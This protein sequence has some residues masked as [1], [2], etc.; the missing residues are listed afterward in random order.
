M[1][2][3]GLTVELL[4]GRGEVLEGDEEVLLKVNGAVKQKVVH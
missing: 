2:L 4:D 3:D 1:K